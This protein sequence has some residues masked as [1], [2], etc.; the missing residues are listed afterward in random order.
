M[1]DCQ[2]LPVGRGTD[3]IGEV[4]EVMKLFYILLYTLKMMNVNE[5]KVYFNKLEFKK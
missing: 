2:G 4:F 3:K 1:S 5:Y